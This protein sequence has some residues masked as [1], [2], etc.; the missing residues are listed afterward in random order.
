[1]DQRAVNGK[2]ISEPKVL[3]LSPLLIFVKVADERGDVQNC[4]VHQHGLNFLYQATVGSRVALFGHDN[5]RKQFVVTHFTVMA[6]SASV[7]S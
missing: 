4:L 7:A 6:S 3:K 1:M 2:I 5:R